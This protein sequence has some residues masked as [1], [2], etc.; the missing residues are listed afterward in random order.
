MD[1]TCDKSPRTIPS[2]AFLKDNLLVYRFAIFNLDTTI[3]PKVIQ[4]ICEAIVKTASKDWARDY[5]VE[6]QIKIYPA[7]RFQ[8]PSLV[9]GDQIP[10]YIL[11]NLDLGFLGI[12]YVNVTG[13]ANQNSI[14][15]GGG[16]V[17][18]F[19][20]PNPPANFA[21]FLPWGAIYTQAMRD[22]LSS[23]I[24]NGNPYAYSQPSEFNQ[25][26]SWFL[27]ANIESLIWNEELTTVVQFDNT[28]PT[29]TSWHYAILDENGNPTNG[30]LGPDGFVR[31][32]TF[33]EAFPAG[34]FFFAWQTIPSPVSL[35]AAAKLQSYCVD[36]WPMSN[37]VNRNF[38]NA[39]FTSNNRQYDKK[40]LVELPGQPFA[41]KLAGT[42]FIDLSTGQSSFLNV[43]NYG[44]V[45]AAQRGAPP[46]QNYPPNY[47]IVT[48]DP[49][50]LASA[51]AKAGLQRLRLNRKFVL[52]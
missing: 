45:T 46:E 35:I 20:I 24:Y 21:S 1:K 32:P 9:T 44:P 47:T 28:A 8:D 49:L 22:R 37:Y 33:N 25:F 36:G 52:K 34:A 19:V 16:N 15:F 31:L 12:D 3:S 2:W 48:L 4:S 6:V 10:I 23:G 41:G 14:V 29:V 50:P 17:N 13:L 38:W 7:E 5:Q 40:G 27:S 26:L 42:F 11:P 43:I 30:T 39:Y 51:N 18:N